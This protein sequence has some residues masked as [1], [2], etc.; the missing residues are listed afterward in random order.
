M[1]K[2]GGMFEVKLT[3]I[4]TTEQL[5]ALDVILK[6]MYR[7]GIRDPLSTEFTGTLKTLFGGWKD[8]LEKKGVLPDYLAY[9]VAFMISQ[10]ERG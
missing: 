9:A 8:D 3:D 5:K 1:R 4:L 6:E 2:L 7:D 10:G